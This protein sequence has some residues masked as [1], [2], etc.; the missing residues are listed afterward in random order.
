MKNKIKRVGLGIG[1]VVI[2]LGA[3]ASFSEPGT[4]ND[5][6]ITLSYL[7]KF[8]DEKIKETKDYLDIKLEEKEEDQESQ[9]NWEVVEV[10]GGQ[11][12]IGY[13]GTEI[14]LRSGEANSISYISKEF[15][16]GVEVIIENGLTDITAGRDLKMGEEI[17]SNH[18]LIVPRDGGR[19]LKCK[20][21]SFILVKG[22]YTK[23]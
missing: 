15:K 1:A 23:E 10:E 12:L 14:I 17:K 8:V 5:P 21:K 16:N 19:G 13:K 9:G 2:L 18:L 11:S 22:E 4:E 20:T 7:N 6:L 3:R